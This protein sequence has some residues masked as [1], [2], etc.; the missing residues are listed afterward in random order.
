MPGNEGTGFTVSVN[1]VKVF[2]KGANWVPPDSLYGCVEADKYRSL[3]TAAKQGN[4]NMLRVW[5]GGRYEIPLFYELCDRLGL[6]IWQDFMFT[7]AYYADD[8]K[9]FMNNIRIEFNDVIKRLRNYTCVTLWCGNNEINWSHPGLSKNVSRFYGREIYSNILPEYI[10][11]LDGTRPYRVSTPYGGGDCNSP[12]EGNTHGWHFWLP[13]EDKA[14]DYRSFERDL[15][16]FCIEYGVMSYPNY[17]SVQ[18]YTRL[19]SVTKNDLAFRAVK[20]NIAH[21]EQI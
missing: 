10:E 11:K 9:E 3:L 21:T 7:N 2:C 4:F 8:D 12:Y 15:S 13:K 5:G 14:T 18:E 17:R 16:K 20:Q 6:M 19:P 1:G